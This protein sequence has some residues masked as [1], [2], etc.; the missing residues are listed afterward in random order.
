MIY[1][2]KIIIHHSGKD[3]YSVFLKNTCCLIVFKLFLYAFW[4][5][6]KNLSLLDVLLNY[7][8]SPE[9]FKT[10][11]YHEIILLLSAY[12]DAIMSVGAF[13]SLVGCQCV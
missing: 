9:N 3:S 7:G 10:P 2:Y 12:V 6:N 8:L 5:L 4:L 11:F 13:F 1:K